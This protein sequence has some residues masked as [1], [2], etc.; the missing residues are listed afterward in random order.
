MPPIFGGMVSI[1][2]IT[3]SS[4]VLAAQDGT[5]NPSGNTFAS[6][7]LIIGIV[8]F[9][10]SLGLAI[11]WWRRPEQFKLEH[12]MRED[13]PP[14]SCMFNFFAFLVSV[15]ILSLSALILVSEAKKSDSEGANPSDIYVFSSIT[16]SSACIALIYFGAYLVNWAIHKY[17]A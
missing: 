7:Q 2:V 14:P 6:V 10:V 13:A 9:L 1:L 3:L 15:S 12:E 11:V 4:L 8:G 17:R 5:I 16:I